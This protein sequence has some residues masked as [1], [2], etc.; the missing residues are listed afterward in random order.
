MGLVFSQTCSGSTEPLENISEIV[1]Y[2]ISTKSSKEPVTES[3]IRQTAI[4][5]FSLRSACFWRTPSWAKPKI[6]KASFVC[7]SAAVHVYAEI[8]HSN[9]L[10]LVWPMPNNERRIFVY[11]RVECE[12]GGACGGVQSR[13]MEHF[14]ILPLEL[15]LSRG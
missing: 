2:L 14:E 4:L 15:F 6:P 3:T 9:Q 10:K 7:S 13:S 8:V 12:P 11:S 1:T 5:T